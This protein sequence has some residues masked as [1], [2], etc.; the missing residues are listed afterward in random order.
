MKANPGRRIFPIFD[1]FGMV[2]N[3]VLGAAARPFLALSLITMILL[4]LENMTRLASRA[5]RI[6]D[7]VGFLFQ[8]SACLLP[9]HLAAALPIVV[10]LAFALAIRRLSLGQELTALW[11][12]GRSAAGIMRVPMLT[13][14]LLATVHVGLRG[15]VEPMGERHLDTIGSALAMGDLGVRFR[16]GVPQVISPG[17]TLLVDQ[18][19]TDGVLTGI[20]AIADGNTYTARS[21]QL[22]NAGGGRFHLSLR[23]GTAI[24]APALVRSVVRFG[25]FDIPLQVPYAAFHA[26]PAIDRLDRLGDGALMH[27]LGKPGACSWAWSALAARMVPA[28]LILLMP[29]F[30]YATAQTSRGNSPA[31][32]VAGSAIVVGMVALSHALA[33]QPG[34]LSAGSQIALLALFAALTS[35]AWHSTAR[36]PDAFASAVEKMVARLKP[37]VAEKPATAKPAMSAAI[38]PI[39]RHLPPPVYG[40]RVPRIP[41]HRRHDKVADRQARS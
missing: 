23:D 3:I 14:V 9:E 5:D 8:S 7:P 16:A 1:R 15:W 21:G 18:A 12:V 41:A 17:V 35:W 20:V 6:A 33:T 32:L 25:R 31:G 36:L 19:S 13:A 34:I 10:Y 38:L 11:S 2:D 28:C 37:R 22:T 30:A 40:R 26:Q 24:A 39:A 27:L 29:C 4:A